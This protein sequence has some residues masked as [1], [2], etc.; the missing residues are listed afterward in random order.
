MIL[1]DGWKPYLG[2]NEISHR[3]EKTGEV[4]PGA[5][6]ALVIG[7]T[8]FHHAEPDPRGLSILI[9]SMEKTEFGFSYMDYIHGGG[10]LQKSSHSPLLWARGASTGASGEIQ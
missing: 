8:L 6:V 3:Y 5:I 9:D 10:E 4:Y 1:S 2:I 7:D